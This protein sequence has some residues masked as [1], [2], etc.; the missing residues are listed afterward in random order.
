MRIALVLMNTVFFMSLSGAFSWAQDSEDTEENTKTYEYLN[1]EAPTMLTLGTFKL[2]KWADEEKKD[3]EMKEIGLSGL[4]TV[5]SSQIDRTIFIIVQQHYDSSMTPEVVPEDLCKARIHWVRKSFLLTPDSGKPMY[6]DVPSLFSR[7]FLQEPIDL[8]SEETLHL[9]SQ[10]DK[11]G[12][13][14][15]H[16]VDKSKMT[17]KEGWTECRAALVDEVVA[18]DY[19]AMMDHLLMKSYSTDQ[20]EWTP[21]DLYIHAV[22]CAVVAADRSGSAEEVGLSEEALLWKKRGASMLRSAKAIYPS[23]K[24][25]ELT[26]E[27]VRDTMVSMLPRLSD[28][29]N[30]KNAETFCRGW[31]EDAD[32]TCRISPELCEQP[33]L[34]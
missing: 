13:V 26:G 1:T 15:V 16:V 2:E 33:E 11:L 24:G 21:S 19:S 34:P 30:S 23:W 25:Q 29:E 18:G 20:K 17:S 31:F 22:T 27:I 6:N 3:L 4:L 9:A 5:G 12:K 28:P 7:L 8:K 32:K 10:I 14:L